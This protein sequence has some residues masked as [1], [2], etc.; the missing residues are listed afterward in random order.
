MG[1]EP[2]SP[3][4]VPQEPPNEGKVKNNK[5]AYIQV[6]DVREDISLHD[7]AESARDSMVEN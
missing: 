7:N 1:G 2:I 3:I 6:D 4:E 5:D